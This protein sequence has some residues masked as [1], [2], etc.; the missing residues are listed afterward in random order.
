MTYNLVIK[1]PYTSLHSAKRQEVEQE[2]Q[3][4]QFSKRIQDGMNK[5]IFQSTSFVW[6]SV[7]NLRFEYCSWQVCPW[8]WI[9]SRFN[10]EFQVE[11][12]KTTSAFKVSDPISD[13][14]WC[15]LSDFLLRLW[16]TRP[17]R[18]AHH[19]L[20]TSHCL[21]L[22]PLAYVLWFPSVASHYTRHLTLS[23]IPLTSVSVVRN[24]FIP[25]F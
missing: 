21:H 16:Y 10:L 1:V 5:V 22:L 12:S 7:L 9:S 11:L 25:D 2:R 19:Q 8:M 6:D 18:T 23:L 13:D 3:K 4:M 20:D 15:K 24:F 17:L 14:D